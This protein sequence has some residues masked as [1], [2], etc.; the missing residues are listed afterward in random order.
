MADKKI[1]IEFSSMSEDMKLRA[2]E[3][4]IAQDKKIIESEP[5]KLAKEL[6]R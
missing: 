1:N 2:I 3:F 6:K 4:V 5:G